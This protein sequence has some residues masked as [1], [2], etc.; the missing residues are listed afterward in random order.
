MILKIKNVRLVILFFTASILFSNKSNE[1]LFYN[2]QIL[3][4][5]PHYIEFDYILE[6]DYESALAHLLEIDGISC[7]LSHDYENFLKL[8]Y[9]QYQ[10]ENIRFIN[11]IVDPDIFY[12]SG[13]I[14]TSVIIIGE[15]NYTFG[16]TMGFHIDSPYAFKLLRKT[17]VL[18]LKSSFISL[19]PINNFNWD[20][21]RAININSTYSIKLGKHIYTLTGLGLT[22]NSNN[23]GT[24]ILP[25]ISLDLAYEFP[26]KPLNI[27]FDI[28][29]CSSASWDLRN[30]YIGFNLLLCKPYKMKISM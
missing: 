30:V 1:D 10:K 8:Y 27:P 26:W 13:A 6:N 17:I 20:S 24:S 18:G 12:I 16:K 15:N 2:Y 23:S 14:G 9:S 4:G 29:F 28:T 19:P 7:Q 22:L 3:N 11:A 21:F 5:S 25:L